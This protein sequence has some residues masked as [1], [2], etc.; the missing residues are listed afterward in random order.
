M[1]KAKKCCVCIRP[2]M[3]MFILCCP[4]IIVDFYQGYHCY[5]KYPTIRTCLYIN[6]LTFSS[7]PIQEG[8]LRLSKKKCDIQ[9]FICRKIHEKHE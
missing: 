2:D 8:N 7:F 9:Y 3:R 4:E 5:L 6:F 1:T